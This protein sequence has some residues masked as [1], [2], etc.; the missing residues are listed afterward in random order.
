MVIGHKFQS[1]TSIPIFPPPIKSAI[2]TGLGLDFDSEF[3][4]RIERFLVLSFCSWFV[5][6]NRKSYMDMESM[7]LEWGSIIS[8]EQPISVGV[9]AKENTASLSNNEENRVEHGLETPK[10][11][12]LIYFWKPT[13]YV[14]K[15]IV[16]V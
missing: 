4:A 11:G 10:K 12:D 8:A 2:E 9:V 7:W 1:P 5:F 13:K 3:G 14:R 16:V 6:M 15:P